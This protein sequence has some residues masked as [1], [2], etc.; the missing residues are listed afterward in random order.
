MG[1]HT[2]NIMVVKNLQDALQ[3]FLADHRKSAEKDSEQEKVSATDAT[4][5]FQDQPDCGCDDCQAAA[6]LLG[7]LY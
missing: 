3:A 1:R 6:Q 2:G 5:R 7:R 4:E